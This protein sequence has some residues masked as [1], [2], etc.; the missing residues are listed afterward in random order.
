MLAQT[1]SQP[2]NSIYM[3]IDKDL[4]QQAQ[5]AMDGL[6][7]A[8]VVMEVNTGKVLAMVSSPGYDPEP[9]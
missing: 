3:T 5:D 1:D 8:I 4:Q 9:V 2:A 7:G 6:P